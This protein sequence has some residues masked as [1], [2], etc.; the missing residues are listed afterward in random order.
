M[1][2]FF[3]AFTFTYTPVWNKKHPSIKMPAIGPAF[4]LYTMVFI[5]LLIY[6]K[7]LRFLNLNS[8]SDCLKSF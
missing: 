1:Q 5:L 7:H 2:K 4:I 6:L 8:G 3:N